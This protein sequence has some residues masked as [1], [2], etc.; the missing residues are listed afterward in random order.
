MIGCAV[1]VAL[2]GRACSPVTRDGESIGFK[3]FEK[4]R[5]TRRSADQRRA[6]YG[7]V[8]AYT[9]T[10]HFEFRILGSHSSG[11]RRWNDTE[12]RSIE[13][14]IQHVVLRVHEILEEEEVYSRRHEK[15]I[16]RRD[17]QRREK[18]RAQERRAV[19]LARQQE[20]EK[21]AQVWTR[22]QELAAYVTGMERRAAGRKLTPEAA[23]TFEEWVRHARTH[24]RRLEKRV[25]PAGL[26]ESGG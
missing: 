25:L 21:H 16:Q 22:S 26:E 11:Q 1:E 20:L 18:K 12:N 7:Q 15:E 10:G 2:H 17:K 14:R 24:V 3:L 9:P 4:S 6:A 8:Y 13:D 23:A 5:Q 19:A